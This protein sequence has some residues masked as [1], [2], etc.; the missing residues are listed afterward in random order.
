VFE[1]QPHKLLHEWVQQA[2]A[3]MGAGELALW[4]DWRIHGEP[5]AVLY[6]TGTVDGIMDWTDLGVPGVEVVVP[7]ADGPSRNRDGTMSNFPAIAEWL[8]IN[9]TIRVTTTE[10]ERLERIIGEVRTILMD[11]SDRDLDRVEQAQTLAATG[12]RPN[13][14]RPDHLGGSSGALS[15]SCR[16]LS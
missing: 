9:T 13:F 7:P 2:V 12:S 14:V 10:R 8:R 5:T 16:A 3:I 11:L 4:R 1:Q 6:T 15:G